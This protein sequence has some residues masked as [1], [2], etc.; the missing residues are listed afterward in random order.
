MG[1]AKA[2]KATVWE[3]HPDNAQVYY[4][5]G[6]SAR[7]VVRALM[8]QVPDVVAFGVL[9]DVPV[10]VHISVTWVMDGSEPYTGTMTVVG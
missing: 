10:E 7:S 6:P 4:S 3:S 2:A 1:K 5:S 9:V 8:Q